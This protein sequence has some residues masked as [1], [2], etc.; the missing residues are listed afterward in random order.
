MP[1]RLPPRLRNRLGRQER[2]GALLLNRGKRAAQGQFAC[3]YLPIVIR[4]L[5]AKLLTRPPRH[6]LSATDRSTASIT[7]RRGSAGTWRGPLPTR[8]PPHDGGSQKKL[9][10]AL[11]LSK[12]TFAPSRHDASSFRLNFSSSVRRAKA[13]PPTTNA[14]AESIEHSSRDA[15]PEALRSRSLNTLNALP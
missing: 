2:S 8:R 11:P 15:R 10:G 3:A 7:V 6:R 1:G 9:I 12:S 14:R 5:N 13:R 4:R